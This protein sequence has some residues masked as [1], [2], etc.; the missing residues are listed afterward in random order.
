MY[1][2]PQCY[3][4]ELRQKICRI[5]NIPPSVVHLDIPSTRHQLLNVTNKS[6]VQM[7]VF[8]FAVINLIDKTEFK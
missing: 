8:T 4:T 6:R 7:Q 2:S 3:C 1:A 5:I